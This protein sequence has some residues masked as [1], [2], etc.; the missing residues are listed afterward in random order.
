MTGKNL[1]H[2][3]I[4]ALEV[5]LVWL[6]TSLLYRPPSLRVTLA[7]AAGILF[8]VPIDFAAGNLLSIYSPTRVE[9]Y[10]F[11]RQRASLL[12]VLASIG[13]RGVL[14]GG[15]GLMLLLS[16]LYGN[17]WIVLPP[18]LSSLAYVLVLKRID[19][20]ALHQRENIISQLG[21]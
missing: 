21:P 3:A 12:T 20:I 9:A 18:A 16:R 15:A 11:G 2:A 13:I 19:G 10:G 5:A 4:F 6:G 1:A 8:A 17:V 7:T 14:F